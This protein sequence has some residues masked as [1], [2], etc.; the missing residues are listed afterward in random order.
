MLVNT[1]AG[2]ATVSAGTA[3]G[4]GIGSLGNDGGAGSRAVAGGAGGGANS[5]GGGGGVRGGIAS[6]GGSELKRGAGGA[7]G[8]GSTGLMGRR[9]AASSRC[10]ISARLDSSLWAG[11]GGSAGPAG[12]RFGSGTGEIWNTGS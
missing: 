5:G 11:R 7:D 6:G 3:A 12:M 2:R 4:S 9:N 1:G 8:T 10:A